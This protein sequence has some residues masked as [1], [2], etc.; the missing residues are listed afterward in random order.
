MHDSE[1]VA[2]IAAGDADALAAA[3]DRYAAPLHAFCRSLLTDPAEAAGAVQDTF[4]IAAAR[5]A[6]L[7][8][9][10]CLK[11][12]LFA[13]AR[14]E[15]HRRLRALSPAAGPDEADG[16]TGGPA[17]Y[18]P[19]LERAE[20][21]EMVSWA[22]AE[23]DPGNR[24][25][26]ELSLRQDLSGEDLALA[27]GLSVSQADAL[28]ARACGQF[29]SFLGAALVAS[30]GRVSCAKLDELLVDWDGRLTGP[31]R[32]RVARHIR[33]CGTCSARRDRELEPALL[34][35]LGPAMSA[36]R[37]QRNQ[38]L[39]LISSGAPGAAAYRTAV[40]DRA[41]AF[42]QSGFPAPSEPPAPGRRLRRPAPALIAAAAAVV[43][44]GAVLLGVGLHHSHRPVSATAALGSKIASSRAHTPLSPRV[45][46]RRVSSSRARGARNAAPALAAVTPTVSVSVTPTASVR[47]PPTPSRSPRPSLSPSPSSSPPPSSGTLGVSPTSVTLTVPVAGGPASGSF[48]LTANGGPVSY[49]VTVPAQYAGTLAVSSSGGSLAAG[50]SVTISVTWQSTA[51]VQTTLSVAPGGQAVSVSY[52]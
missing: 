47:V 6:G 31:M 9:R 5:L 8:D 7:H 2:A 4:V 43:A 19:D 28:T 29:E 17:G 16:R 25:V 21:P 46:S 11:S 40:A 42:A 49:A 15:C 38:V 10:D 41:G 18:G 12:W 50:G 44:L 14:N 3:Y 30:T 26:V 48:T 27:L 35:S 45:A 24:E 37:G 51:A 52:P 33:R 34:L 32:D 1:I 23:L 39:A 13:V 36:A 22:F 20:P